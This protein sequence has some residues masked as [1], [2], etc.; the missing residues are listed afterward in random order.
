MKKDLKT[1]IYLL[2]F[3]FGG[4]ACSMGCAQATGDATEAD[5]AADSVSLSNIQRLQ[6]SS[7]DKGFIS[8]F[9]FALSFAG[10][11]GEIG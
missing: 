6:L 8:P 3:L 11:F 1:S 5:E 9:D 7:V 10:N 4:A 2:I